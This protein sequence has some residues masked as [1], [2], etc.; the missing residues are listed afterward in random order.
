MFLRT[1]TPAPPHLL[2]APLSPR[3]IILW[4][5]VVEH[6]LLLTRNINGSS[7]NPRLHSDVFT[8]TSPYCCCFKVHWFQWFHC[9]HDAIVAIVPK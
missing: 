2:E 3:S 5:D 4:L 7:L 8:H 6:S 1:G 9:H